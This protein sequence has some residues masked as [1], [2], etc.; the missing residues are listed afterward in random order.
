MER[1]AVLNVLLDFL[2]KIQSDPAIDAKHIALFIALYKRWVVQNCK[3]P[4]KIKSHL[5]MEESKISSSATYF[6]KIKH[7]HEGEYIDYRPSNYW[8]ESSRVSFLLT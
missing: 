1:A 4:I 6:K 3:N 8:K 2:H 5:I 7:L